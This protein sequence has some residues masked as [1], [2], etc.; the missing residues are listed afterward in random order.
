MSNIRSPT[1]YSKIF[2][3]IEETL[4]EQSTNFSRFEDFK[5]INNKSLPTDDTVFKT[6]VGIVFYSGMKAATVT[7]R[8]PAIYEYLGDY[9]KA[10]QLDPEKMLMDNRVIR[11]KR[12][13]QGCI[14]NGK[15]FEKIIN[16]YGS[17][18]NYL[19]SF[20][21]LDDLEVLN[22]IKA[23]F[24]S[25]FDYIS[26]ITAY[27][28]M[29]EL[30][31][32]VLKPDRVICRI[33]QRLGFI[34]DKDDLTEAV[35]VGRKIAEATNQPIRYVDIIFVKYGQKGSEEGFGIEDGICLENPR[36]D[37]CSITQYC[38]DYNKKGSLPTRIG[39]QKATHNIRVGNSKRGTDAGTC[40]KC[41]G[42]LVWRK[43]R[44]TG[45]LYRGCT[46][47]QKWCRW[48]DRSY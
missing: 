8:L 3:K 30:G 47:F 14:V 7:N 43:A 23:D 28:L 4:R 16:Q 26:K 24:E 5:K 40:P 13:I 29:T 9:K 34:Q 12:K 19:R 6:I 45:E 41:G 1:D 11:Y 35:E 42:R 33:F 22:R 48:Q 27:H 37:R 31:L 2:F 46:N 39:E 17:F 38:N 25:R 15:E 20:G 21:N 44:K 36:C 32:N 10:T 18:S